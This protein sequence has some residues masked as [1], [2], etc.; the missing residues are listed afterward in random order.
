M[1]QNH[2]QRLLCIAFLALTS[3][4]TAC[5][6]SSSTVN[7]LRPDR[8]I[9]FGD[10]FNAVNAAG[11]GVNTVQAVVGTDLPDDTIAG[12]LAYSKYGITLT[13]VSGAGLLDATKKGFSYAQGLARIQDAATKLA[14]PAADGVEKQISNFLTVNKPGEK[15]LFII[16]AGGLDIYDAFTNSTTLA[17][18]VSAFVAA[19]KRLTDAGAKYVLIVYPPNM[20]R[21]PW[22]A[23]RSAADRQAIQDLSYDTQANC[24]KGREVSFSCRTTIALNVEFPAT[25]S[26]QPVLYADLMGYS[27]LI[28]GTLGTSTVTFQGASITTTGTGNQNT[29][30]AYGVTNPDLPACYNVTTPPTSPLVCATTT[31]NAAGGV[32]T[33]TNGWT[34]TAWDYK[35]SVFADNF[36]FTPFTNRLVADYIFNVTM[37][38][39]GWR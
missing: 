2:F 31:T 21:T 28:T 9:A 13:S 7:P 14:D 17:S 16:S 39:A 27:N 6:G 29:F 12:R 33:G 32:N 23:R 37:Y 20:A 5:G 26:H 35:T 11:Y 1:T 15:D 36:Y 25:S 10:G 19:I 24:A 4:L 8:V 38:R 3:L 22:A 34:N 18:P 30:P